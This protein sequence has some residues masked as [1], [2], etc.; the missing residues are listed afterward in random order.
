MLTNGN[1][2]D[3]EGEVDTAATQANAPRMFVYTSGSSI[4]PVIVL[5]SPQTIDCNSTSVAWSRRRC[6]FRKDASN[7]NDA[8]CT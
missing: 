5:S 7:D 1:C 3:S 6:L 4:E 2:G 8:I